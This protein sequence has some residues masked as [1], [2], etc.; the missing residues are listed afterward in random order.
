MYDFTRGARA[1]VKNLKAGVH[2][3]YG[4][5]GHSKAGVHK[6]YGTSGH[7]SAAVDAFWEE[8]ARMMEG[9]LRRVY[10]QGQDGCEE[11]AL[12]RANH[13]AMGG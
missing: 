9:L 4:T 11:C 7:S 8:L 13:R 1:A 3:H 10:K 2:K 6:H 5:S 12:R